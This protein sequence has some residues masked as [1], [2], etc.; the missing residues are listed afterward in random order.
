MDK[1]IERL[2]STKQWLGEKNSIDMGLVSHREALGTITDAITAL[3]QDRAAVLEEVISFVAE[4]R[5]QRD[6]PWDAALVKVLDKLYAM[7]TPPATQ[8][9]L[10]DGCNGDG[11][12][13]VC[14]MACV[15]MPC[16]SENSCKQAEPKVHDRRRHP[17]SMGGFASCRRKS[18]RR[19]PAVADRRKSALGDSSML[20]HKTGRRIDET[21]SFGRREGDRARWVV[22]KCGACNGTGR[23]PY[24][25]MAAT[26]DDCPAC[27]DVL[28]TPPTQPAAE[29]PKMYLRESDSRGE[30]ESPDTRA[31]CA[32]EVSEGG[33]LHSWLKN[34]PWLEDRPLDAPINVAFMFDFADAVERHV[35]DE[36]DKRGRG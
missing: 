26:D 11:T 34:K 15:D 13:H 27:A 24:D 23:T 7:K 21:D 35:R 18:R 22:E 29:V 28:F 3:T 4:Q 8:A 10:C 25:D 12:Y 20:P 5:C 14:G 9:K 33:Y 2:Q 32:A 31:P 16:T 19:N 30:Y 6:T 17:T 1:L 36:L